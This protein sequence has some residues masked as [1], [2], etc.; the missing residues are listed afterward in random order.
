MQIK[1][2]PPWQIMP[3]DK[4]IH[5]ID[6]AVQ[7]A[8]TRP[9]GFGGTYIEYRDRYGLPASFRRRPFDRVSKVVG[10]GGLF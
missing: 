5:E 3:G 6:G 10:R 4:I 9:D 1:S 8:F 2:V 7:V